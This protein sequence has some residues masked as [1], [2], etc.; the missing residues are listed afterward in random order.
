MSGT[1]SLYR[2]TNECAALYDAVTDFTNEDGE[3]DESFL[4]SLRQ[5]T[6]D[7]TQKALS[8]A[9]LVIAFDGFSDAL[10]R[11]IA[12]LTAAKKRVDRF[13]ERTKD[14]LSEACKAV[15][16][17]KVQG[18][19][20]TISFRSST[21]VDP[22]DPSAIPEEFMRVKVSREPNLTEIG[23]ALK[24]GQEVPGCSLIYKK[25]IQIK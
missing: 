21:A 14:G 9:D 3:V 16:M 17:E 8:V 20:T 2:L 11:E 6:D 15:G 22:Y 18:E 19:Y 4:T 24:A 13:R 25:N 23:K 10:G 1:T 12:R 7:W 5:K